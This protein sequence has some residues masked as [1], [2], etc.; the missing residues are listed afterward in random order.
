MFSSMP[1]SIAEI[2]ELW[3]N[4]DCLLVQLWESHSICLRVASEMLK[5]DEWNMWMRDNADSFLPEITRRGI[6]DLSE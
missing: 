3:L 2:R 5:G 1:P 6:I 4:L